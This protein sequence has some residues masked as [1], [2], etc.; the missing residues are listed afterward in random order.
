MQC[1][2]CQRENKPDSHFCIFC[3]FLL[4]ATDA[5][6]PATPAGAGDVLPEQ[7]RTLQE[8]VQHL[9]ELVVLMNE[10]LAILESA[11]GVA[12]PSPEP[13]PA[14]AAVTP[15]LEAAAVS[16]VEAPPPIEIPPP[17]REVEPPKARAKGVRRGRRTT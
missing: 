13:M 16:P 12:A 7:L 8:E 4:P 2:N 6:Q 9:R 10:R 5:E 14:P 1:P 3:G 17:P 15:G 11:Q